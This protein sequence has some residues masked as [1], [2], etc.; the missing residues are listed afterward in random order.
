MKTL[1]K[2]MAF[3]MVVTML[4]S[5]AACGSKEAQNPSVTSTPV[6]TGTNEPAA[7]EKDPETGLTPMANRTPIT[8]HMFIRDPGQAPDPNNPVLK[9]ITELT[10]VTIEFEF[11]VGDLNEKIGVLLASGEY[12]E[13]M[14]GADAKKFF[15]AGALVPLDDYIMK[16]P[17]LRAHYE[18]FLDKMRAGFDGEH[19]YT[20]ENYNL[21]RIPSPIFDNGGAGFWIQKAVIEEAGYKIPRTI[22]EYFQMIN[23]YRAKHPTIDGVETIGFAI[24]CDGWRDF[25]LRNPALHLLGSTNEGDVIVDKTT[26]K[27][28]L[29]QIT[30]TAKLYYKKLNEEF[31]KGT[32][33]ADT[34]T[35]TFD[36][37][38]GT[39]ASG[40][41]LGMFDQHWNFMQGENV[42][43]SEGRYERTYISVPIANPGVTDAYLEAKSGTISGTG[44]ITISTKCKDVDRLM[45]FYDWLLNRE[46]QDYLQWGIEGKDWVRVGTVG[47]KLT[48]ERRAIINDNNKRRDLTGDTLWQYTPKMQ[49]LYEDGAPCG[50][51]DSEDE[52][53]AGLS[54]YDQNFFSK[55]GIKY[56]A[57]ILTVVKNPAY[58][59]VWSFAIEDGSP[60]RLAHAKLEDVCR[61][62][63]P[64]LIMS[65]P[66]KYDS[67]WEQFVAEVK[68]GKPEDYL[69]EVD[70]Q[71]Q[72]KMEAAAKEGN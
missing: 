18:P 58:Y 14:F 61:K 20:L 60:A 63:Y 11:L 2:V 42:L 22:D 54:E 12:P 15:D 67:L 36:E 40:A 33:K 65:D 6:D 21:E 10:G 71:I 1:K 30:D 9:K 4:L 44:G 50:P 13:I 45:A 16:Y 3:L 59:P 66:A 29:Y 26:F 41:V 38:I 64:Q 24:L 19:A 57:Q 47:K 52:F 49:G 37:Y 72:L 17:N 25:C 62:Y 53:F 69:N 27:S 43:K 28:S 70:R 32:I 34:F 8:Y 56:P 23:D 31:R 55:L 5:I 35:Q 46:V 39:I 7:V 48:D 51:A 68:A